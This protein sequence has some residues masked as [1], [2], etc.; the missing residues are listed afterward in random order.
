MSIKIKELKFSGISVRM[1]I[2][3]AKKIMEAVSGTST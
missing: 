2:E 3:V 1:K